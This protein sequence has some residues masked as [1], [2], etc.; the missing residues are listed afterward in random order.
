MNWTAH[1]L[2][3]AAL[4]LGACYVQGPPPSYQAAPPPQ[5]GAPPPEAYTPPP[6]ASAPPAYAP[7]E[8][9]PPEPGGIYVDVE[10]VPPADPAPSVDVFYDSLAP[11]GRWVPDPVYGRVWI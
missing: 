8:Y 1:P 11:Y 2:A 6:Q 5:E 4:A 9:A 7:P 3:V 10:V